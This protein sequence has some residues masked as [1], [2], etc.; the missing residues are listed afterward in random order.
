MD[1][2]MSSRGPALI[3]SSVDARRMSSP[4]LEE[5]RC[6]K[7]QI[8]KT[9]EYRSDI[10]A[11]HGYG[12]IGVVMDSRAP[13]GRGSGPASEQPLLLVLGIRR[14]TALRHITL[15]LRPRPICH[16]PLA[17]LVRPHFSDSS[18]AAARS[19]AESGA[20]LQACLGQASTS[21]RGGGGRVQ[22]SESRMPPR[23]CA[24]P[25]QSRWAPDPYT[26]EIYAHRTLVRV[27]C[28][29]LDPGDVLLTVPDWFAA[30]CD[31]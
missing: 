1:S 17:T 2:L 24:Q 11:E 6:C 10:A 12:V 27:D 8:E 7:P 16:I 25:T 21:R 3:L 30:G 13:G 22:R 20:F 14:A 26:S 9:T 29:A 4:Q 15:T 23:T 18:D 5:C 19:R 28:I 31:V